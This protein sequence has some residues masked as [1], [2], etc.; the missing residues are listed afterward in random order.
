MAG[1][2]A[3]AGRLQEAV[4]RRQAPAQQGGGFQDI[5]RQMQV[6]Q[7]KANLINEQRYQQILGSFEGL[8]QA[9]RARIEEQ[10]TQRQA[11]ATQNLTSRG[12]GGTTITAAAERGIAREGESAIQELDERVT[13][14]KAGVIERRTDAGPDM[15]MF[16]SLLATAGQQQQQPRATITRM[17]AQAQAGRTVFGQP[18]RY[19]AGSTLR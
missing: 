5:I 13:A 9:G 17:G 10:T 2:A 1:F 15:S 19:T 14:Q 6:S 12:L 4:K 11:A 7:E 18:F 3:A 16:S 8:G